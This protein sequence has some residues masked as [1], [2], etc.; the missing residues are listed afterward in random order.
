MGLRGD[1]VAR[2]GFE[3]PCDQLIVAALRD[4]ARQASMSVAQPAPWGLGRDVTLVVKELYGL[5]PEPIMR[6]RALTR[7]RELR[8]HLELAK[9]CIG[10]V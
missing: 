3:S 6:S 5:D 8:A 7:R 4:I 2:P 9:A 10:R 1:E